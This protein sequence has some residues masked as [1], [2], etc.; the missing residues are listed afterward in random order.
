MKLYSSDGRRK[1]LINPQRLMYLSI[2]TLVIITTTTFAYKNTPREEPVVEV[3]V[4]KKV[5]VPAPVLT[6]GEA[7]P[8]LSARAVLAVDMKSGVTIYEK[9]P[10]SQLLPASTTKIVTALIAMDYYDPDEILVVYDPT[11][12][13]KKMGL[14]YGEQILAKDL[15]YALLVYSANDAAEVL[16]QNYPGGREAFV[17]EMNKLASKLSL[18]NSYFTNPAGLDGGDHVSTARDLI[19]VANI[20]MRRPAFA[21]IVRQEN[22]VVASVDGQIVHRIESTNELLGEVEGVFGVKT[23][24]TENAHENLVTYIERDDK[25]VMIAMLASQDRFGESEELI[26]WIF[27]NYTWQDVVMPEVQSYSSE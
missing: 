2:L 12:D 24:W 1:V 16:A 5:F 15:I 3:V 21:N 23:G 27:K 6:G 25:Q 22:G 17:R 20:A 9:N 11:V 18:E 13:G 26:E 8:V 4:D 14:V 7:Y 19:R 10:D